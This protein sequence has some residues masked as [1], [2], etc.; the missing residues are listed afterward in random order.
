MTLIE[1]IYLGKWH[2]KLKNWLETTNSTHTTVVLIAFGRC[3][4]TI[5]QLKVAIP[6]DLFTNSA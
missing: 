1:L 5:L 4:F 6:I 2:L 3:T